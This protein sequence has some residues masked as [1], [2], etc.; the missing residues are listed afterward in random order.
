M[1]LYYYKAA[2]MDGQI[3]EG[4]REAP[5]QGA[6]IDWIQQ[7]GRV[8]IIARELGSGQPGGRRAFLGRRG[9]RIR[10]QEVAEFTDELATLLRSGLALDQA[11]QVMLSVADKEPVRALIARI[12]DAV[13]SGAALSGAL[14]AEAGVFSSFYIAMVRAAEASGTLAEGLGQLAQHLEKVRETREKVL[15]ALIYPLILG[16]VAGLSLIIVLAYVVPKITVLFED[17]E[18]LLPASTRLVIAM[19][20][21]MRGYWWLIPIIG[22]ALAVWIRRERSRPRSR[23]RWDR[24]LLRVPRVGDLVLKVETARFSRGLGTLIAN[25]IPLLSALTIAR[26]TLSN[27]V[28]VQALTE[29]TESLKEG[30]RLGE[31]LM[32]TGHFPKLALQMI[33]VGEESGE[34]EGMLLRVAEVYER[35]TATAVQRLL[36]LIEPVL[37]VGLGLVIGG[38]IISLLTAIMSV[39]D[40][41]L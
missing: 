18:Q 28:L 22:V 35:E 12:Q 33:K 10:L 41:P 24:R 32:Q 36:A 1:P 23:Y 21:L 6:V 15:S 38:I 5:D 11:L 14:G 25:G 37:I 2:S 4:Q 30:E 8:P 9:P 26:D 20:D 40:L 34:L 13:R 3:M 27:R 29:A 31:I 16:C 17:M 19:S 7:T 39:N